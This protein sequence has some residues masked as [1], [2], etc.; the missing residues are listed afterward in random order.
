MK[1]DASVFKGK[2]VQ[3]DLSF[4]NPDMAEKAG[5]LLNQSGALVNV[6]G[7]AVKVSGDLGAILAAGL[8]DADALYHNNDKAIESRYPI[9][10]RE[11]LYCWWLTLTELDKDL[12]KQE[13]FKEA[14]MVNQVVSKAVETAYNYHGIEAQKIS[15]KYGIVAF[16]LIFYVIYTLWYGFAI[17]FMFEGWGMQLESH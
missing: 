5:A 8:E 11:S 10:A 15:E 14:K 13:A 16:S 12:T 17:M 7:N 9:K 3:A 1:E 4:Q 2:A 6:S